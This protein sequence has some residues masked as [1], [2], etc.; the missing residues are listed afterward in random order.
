M[1][2][3]TVVTR[4]ARLDRGRH[5]V[6]ALVVVRNGQAPRAGVQG[7]DRR[8]RELWPRRG[9]VS[10]EFCR[11]TEGDSDEGVRWTRHDLP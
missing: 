5:R 6:G 4:L 10:G 7:G 3:V 9:H 2:G 8:S 1:V 11:H